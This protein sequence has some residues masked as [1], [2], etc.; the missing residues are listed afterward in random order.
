MTAHEIALRQTSRIPYR[1]S[2]H[3]LVGF[4]ASSSPKRIA[5]LWVLAVD[6]SCLRRGPLR[7]TVT[8]V[9]KLRNATP[10]I[11]ASGILYATPRT[12]CNPSCDVVRVTNRCGST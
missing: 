9:P 8:L 4:D 3:H 1:C 7:Q 5:V 10:W 6:D 12:R 2:M 11:S